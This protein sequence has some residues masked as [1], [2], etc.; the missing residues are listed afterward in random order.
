M[1]NTKLKRSVMILLG[2]AVLI[3]AHGIKT[4]NFTRVSGN[5]VSERMQADKEFRQNLYFVKSQ[6]MII[7]EEDEKE[8]A[9]RK[10]NTLEI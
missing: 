6:R 9:R 7:V 2:V 3:G 4:T 8:L 10:E 5:V 1:L